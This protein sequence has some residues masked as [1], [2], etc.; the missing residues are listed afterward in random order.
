MHAH[1]WRAKGA[2]HVQRRAQREDAEAL[3]VRRDV[4]VHRFVLEIGGAGDADQRVLGIEHEHARRHHAVLHGKVGGAAIDLHLVVAEQLGHDVVAHIQAGDLHQAAAD[5]AVVDQH[6]HVAR[7]RAQQRRD[8]IAGAADR[9]VAV[10]FAQYGAPADRR[11]RSG[12]RWRRP[13]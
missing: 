1:V 6:L 8:R 7:R 12:L 3:A 11:A 4:H 5:D 2:A 10:Q 9:Q 13:A